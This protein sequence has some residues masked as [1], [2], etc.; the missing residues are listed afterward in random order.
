MRKR[1]VQIDAAKLA[2][3]LFSKVRIAA[4]H[5]MRM[6][7]AHIAEE[8]NIPIGELMMEKVGKAHRQ[9]LETQSLPGIVASANTYEA[10][11]EKRQRLRREEQLLRRATI[12]QNTDPASERTLDIRDLLSE[13]DDAKQA[14]EKSMQPLP[15]RAA[16]K[17]LEDDIDHDTLMLSSSRYAQ[18]HDGYTYR[19]L[20][21]PVLLREY[22]SDHSVLTDLQMQ[23]NLEAIDAIQRDK[24]RW[25]AAA[26]A[27]GNAS[28]E[29]GRL[30]MADG[31]QAW[32]QHFWQAQGHDPKMLRLIGVARARP[33]LFPF[34][35][36]ERPG[37]RAL[38]H[39]RDKN[40]P[41]DMRIRAMRRAQEE[42]SNGP[43]RR[44]RARAT[45]PITDAPDRSIAP[46]TPSPEA[47][48]QRSADVAPETAKS[49][50]SGVRPHLVNHERDIQR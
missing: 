47:S 10:T 49:T 5:A 46:A 40:H 23:M 25:I 4:R 38:A 33:E 13:Y 16:L 39:I 35:P 7:F 30:K 37:D 32:A 24:R 45:R 17:K 22:A 28:V 19:F 15:H 20:D 26:I 18:S 9:R 12:G 21:D 8:L 36:A 50:R 48:S 6:R 44:T 11:L 43:E 1:R 41:L 42:R 3:L 31:E 14:C 34:D 2:G 27:S 29:N